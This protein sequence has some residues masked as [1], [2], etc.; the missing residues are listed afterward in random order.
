MIAAKAT[1]SRGCTVRPDVDALSTELRQFLSD[2]T[3]HFII[4]HVES[5]PNF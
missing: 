2:Y 5:F 1:P 4:L 3:N